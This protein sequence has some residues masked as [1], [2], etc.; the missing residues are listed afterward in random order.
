MCFGAQ[1]PQRGFEVCG[2]SPRG[3]LKQVDRSLSPSGT[4]R[5]F[6]P[7]SSSNR[8]I[9]HVFNKTIAGR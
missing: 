7:S 9:E 3:E 1:K 4:S 8:F 5:N 2:S 6:T